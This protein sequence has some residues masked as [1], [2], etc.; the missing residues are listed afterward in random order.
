VSSV[1]ITS[2]R[3]RTRPAV[4]RFRAVVFSNPG[5]I[6]G[7]AIVLL[8][9]LLIVFA[10][11]IA[12]FPPEQSNPADRLQAPNGTHWF[13]TDETGMDVFSR[14][15]YAP[16]IDVT[17]AVLVTGI[18]ML[19]GSPLG[20]FAG[21]YAGRRGPLGWLAEGIMRAADVLQAFPL[22]VLA[23]AVVTITGQNLVN[24]VGV[25]AFLYAPV[26]L[27]LTRSQAL[28]IRDRLFVESARSIGNPDRR[29]LVRH[30]VPNSMAPALIQMS[31]NTG[32][33]I[34]LT[35]SLSFVGAGVRVPTP[36][37]GLMIS[38]GA[39]NVVTGEW[40][41]WLFPGMAISL[42][43]LGFALVGESIQRMVDPRTS[44]R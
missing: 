37:W 21:Y 38:T 12:P 29:I 4:E 2:R 42:A 39:S 30:V 28:G 7:Y 9:L 3:R 19:I 5:F 31:V 44:D 23:M 24:L 20:V 34:L 11:L 27:R 15:I 43:V 14:T 32:W 16:R 41:T 36:E 1:A 13:G 22:F 35:A 40:W 18:S 10:P 17:I 6:L 8:L 26:Y 25:L 33:A